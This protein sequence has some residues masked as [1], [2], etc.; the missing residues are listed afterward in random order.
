MAR[1]VSRPTTNSQVIGVYEQWADAPVISFERRYNHILSLNEALARE[2]LTLQKRVCERQLREERKRQNGK[3][4][5]NLFPKE[6]KGETQ[7]KRLLAK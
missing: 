4:A 2:K 5:L 3:P 1:L 6:V 7:A